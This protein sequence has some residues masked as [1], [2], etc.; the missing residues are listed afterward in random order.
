MYTYINLCIDVGGC[1]FLLK[2]F[3]S[4]QDVFLS[5]KRFSTVYN[6]FYVVKI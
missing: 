2:I 6:I 5:P 1:L 4:I 3:D